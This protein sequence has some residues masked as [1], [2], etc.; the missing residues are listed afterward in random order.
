M[1][2]LRRGNSNTPY[3]TVGGANNNNNSMG[4]MGGREEFNGLT[5]GSRNN[6]HMSVSGHQHQ[7]TRYRNHLTFPWKHLLNP[8]F[9]LPSLMLIPTYTSP[10][11]TYTYLHLHFPSPLSPSLYCNREESVSVAR[12]TS[13]LN[14]ANAGLTLVGNLATSHHSLYPFS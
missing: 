8:H 4:Q 10:H 7:Y 13:R 9:Q 12:A 6:N 5:M 3:E 2:R 1:G 11:P 14:A